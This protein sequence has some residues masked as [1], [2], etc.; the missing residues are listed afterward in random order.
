MQ[1][2]V[3]THPGRWKLTPVSGQNNVYDC[4]R[5]DSPSVAGTPLNKATFLTDATASA[6]AA[7][8]VS[9]PSLP[10]EA[11]SGLATVLDTMGVNNVCHIETGSYVGTGTYSSTNYL[12]ITFSITPKFVIIFTAEG[13]LGTPARNLLASWCE[14]QSINGL[15]DGNTEYRIEWVRNNKTLRRRLKSTYSGAAVLM[16]TSGA[17]YYYIGVGTK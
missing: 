12:D 8:G 16:D 9:S 2:R 7:L 17:T 4:E 14:G 13:S 1:D 5:A 6:I 11:L 10:T 3:S 15:K